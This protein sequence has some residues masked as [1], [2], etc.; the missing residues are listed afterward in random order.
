MQEE[1]RRNARNVDKE[2]ENRWITHRKP[3]QDAD[4]RDQTVNER[5]G[6]KILVSNKWGN[7]VFWY[8]M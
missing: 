8:S 3:E 1:K 7:T 4:G 6:M 5:P 2:D